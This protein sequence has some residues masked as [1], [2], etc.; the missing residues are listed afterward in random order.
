MIQPFQCN[1]GYQVFYLVRENGTNKQIML[2]K[3]ALE[4]MKQQIKNGEKPYKLQLVGMELGGKPIEDYANDFYLISNLNV[5]QT[6]WSYITSPCISAEKEQILLW[7]MFLLR[8]HLNNNGFRTNIIKNIKFIYQN[9][10]A[11]R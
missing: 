6:G 8:E 7:A 11:N 3:E 10:Q 9:I 2:G 5:R 4:K 1:L